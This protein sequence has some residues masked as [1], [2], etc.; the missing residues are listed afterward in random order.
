[1]LVT[2]FYCSLLPSSVPVQENIQLKRS[3]GRW[4][5]TVLMYVLMYTYA[6]LYAR[7]FSWV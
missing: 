5:L 2:E 3:K 4:D 7:F 1:M 6:C